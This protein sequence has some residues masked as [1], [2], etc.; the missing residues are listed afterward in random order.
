MFF[1][2]PADQS[3]NDSST[4]F[5]LPLVINYVGYQ[6]VL[7]FLRILILFIL[8]MRASCFSREPGTIWT[9]F[10]I[11]LLSVLIIH[12]WCRSKY[13]CQSLFSARCWTEQLLKMHAVLTLWIAV[14][15]WLWLCVL[16]G[17]FLTLIIFSANVFCSYFSWN[18]FSVSHLPEMVKA[19]S[20]LMV[21]FFVCF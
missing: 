6:N 8:K 16:A 7:Y 5:C 11:S 21:L 2:I 1:Q 19:I 12:P 15:L 13:H 10:H 20:P 4:G 18:R 14:S 17:N 3:V 9:H